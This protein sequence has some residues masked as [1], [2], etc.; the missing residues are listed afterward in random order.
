MSEMSWRRSIDDVIEAVRAADGQCVVL[1]GAGCSKSAGIPLAGGLISE[2]EK[3]FPSAHARAKLN[4]D[5]KNYNKLMGGLTTQQRR[6]LLQE[7]IE[8]AKINWAHL[9][10]AQMFKTGKVDRVLTVNF[11]P[12]LVRACALV[13][14]YPAIY[15]L[16]TASRFRSAAIAPNSVFY[17]NGQHTGFVILNTEDELIA[18]R[19]R[20]SEIVSDTGTR[21]TWIIAGYSGEAD[22]LL[23]VIAKQSC[24][25]GGLFWIGFDPE[26]SENL[27]KC[28]FAQESQPFKDAFYVGNQDA[29]RFFVKLAQ[30]LDVFPPSILAD[31]FLHL[32]ELV[33]NIDFSTGGE[34]EKSLEGILLGKLDH[35]DKTL[36]EIGSNKAQENPENWL[37]GGQ[38][39]K[40]LRWFEGISQPTDADKNHVA[41]AYVMIGNSLTERAKKQSVQEISEARHLWDQAGKQY[42]AALAIKANLDDAAFNWGVS[43]GQEARAVQEKD[44]SEARRLW[45][46]VGEKYQTALAINADKYEA[47]INWGLA[48]DEEARL[49]QRHEFEE[50]R[51]LWK[52]AGE[53][54]QAALEIK[55][56]SHEAFSNWGVALDQEARAVLSQNL[57]EAR[58]LWEQAGEKYQAALEIKVDMPEALSNW[59]IALAQEARAVVSE[60]LEKARHLWGLASEKYEA[61]LAINPDKHE[62]LNSWGHALDEEARTIAPHDLVEARQLWVLAGQ[63]Y[64]AALT[65]KPDKHEVLNSWGC[66]LDREALAVQNFDL[67]EARRLWALA[68]D[69]Y[70]AVLVIAPDSHDA[71]NNWGVALDREARAVCKFDLAEANRLWA[72]AGEKYSAALTINPDKHE[73][74]FNWGVALAEQAHAIQN[75]DIAEARCLWALAE[76]KYLQSLEIKPQYDDAL[77]NLA[78]LY[79]VQWHATG[80]Q[81]EKRDLLDK[82]RASCQQLEAMM[83]GKCAYNLACTYAVEGLVDDCIKWLKVADVNGH[84]PSREHLLEDRDLDSVRTNPSFSLWWNERFPDL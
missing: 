27:R 37:L 83:P 56:D 81:Q 78:A 19:E 32:R 28:L 45:A 44:L 42:Q 60:D 1:I 33:A 6:Q 21:R 34:Y 36:N 35:C 11:D 46:L 70:Q 25:D 50:A 15:D 52:L 16:A 39:E 75:V 59:G 22:P 84:L 40:V 68:G 20:L 17:L 31:P 47:L 10:L 58:R 13:G 82:A 43:L 30:Q 64:L 53:K 9:A 48:L 55:V 69:K 4:G 12:L 67:S 63:K 2:I 76:A 29:D 62:V 24:F 8:K 51:R 54:Y 3:K 49:V 7:H 14:H 23:E 79:L 41:W 77:G 26:P 57:K 71:P 18:H 66:A 72:L 38:Y 65:I 73:T 61:A 5:H 80:D 74:L